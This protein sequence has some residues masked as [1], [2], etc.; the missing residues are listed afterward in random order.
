[1]SKL[2]DIMKSAF[3]VHFE[4][5]RDGALWYVV[6]YGAEDAELEAEQFAFRIPLTDVSGAVFPAMDE[7]PKYY[8]RWI[9][10]QLEANAAEAQMIAQARAE[11][12]P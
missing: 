7:N 2:L 8:Q 11:W 6:S 12:N 4:E 1:M 10:E 9:R 3:Y 5:C